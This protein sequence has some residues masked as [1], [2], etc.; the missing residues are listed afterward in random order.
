MTLI[1]VILSFTTWLS[2]VVWTWFLS[3]C[4]FSS[5]AA[6]V[7]VAVWGCGVEVCIYILVR[8]CLWKWQD[9][10][11]SPHIFSFCWPVLQHYQDFQVTWELL[12]W[13]FPCLCNYP[14]E[15]IR[16]K[17]STE[18]FI[19]FPYSYSYP[20]FPCLIPIPFS[21]FTMVSLPYE[22]GRGFW[23]TIGI[24]LNDLLHAQVQILL[25]TSYHAVHVRG[26][27]DR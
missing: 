2:V 11:C 25:L 10:K 27:M 22:V 13:M 8:E 3:A 26:F 16:R 1:T 21:G 17:Q 4:Y 24:Q 19:A 12:L 7:K 5:L 18:C 9:L 20:G 14:D 15:L 6:I 23:L